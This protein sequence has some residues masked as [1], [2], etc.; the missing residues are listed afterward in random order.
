MSCG[1]S[2]CFFR[3]LDWPHST[4]YFSEKFDKSGVLKNG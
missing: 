4:L 1:L 2:V 3:T